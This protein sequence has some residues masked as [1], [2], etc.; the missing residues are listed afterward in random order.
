MTLTFSTQDRE[1]VSMLEDL[2]NTDFTA[3]N[4]STETSRL[5]GYFCS[6]TKFNLS[7]KV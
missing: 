3:H 4:N 2:K 5:K 7:K 1:L 6:E